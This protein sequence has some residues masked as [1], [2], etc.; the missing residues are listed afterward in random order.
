MLILLILLT[1]IVIGFRTIYVQK[2]VASVASVELS[3]F[4]HYKVEIDRLEIDWFDHITVYGI[5]VYDYQNT[6]MIYLGEVQIDY[7]I[8]TF[9]KSFAYRIQEATLKDGEVHLINYKNTDIININEFI[10]GLSKV[11]GPSTDTVNATKPFTIQDVKLINMRFAFDDFDNEHISGFDHNHFSF[12]SIYG[13]T[14]DL[15]V[16]A[17]TLRI[18]IKDLTTI[19]GGTHMRVHKLSGVYTLCGHY[20]EL[21]NMYAR[22]GNSFLQN[23]I[24]FSYSTIT[25]LADF[26]TKT[27]IKSTLDS[28]FIDL[29]DISHFASAL[30]P[31]PYKIALSGNVSGT[32]NKFSISKLNLYT[33]KSFLRGS[34]HM[35]GLPDFKKTYIDANFKDVNINQAE[36]A[37]FFNSDIG[38]TLKIVNYFKGSIKFNGFPENFVANAALNTAIGFV[39]TDMAFHL[40][41]NI[42]DDSYYSGKLITKNLNIG[43][44]IKSDQLGI[45]NMDGSVE[46]VGFDINK[47][48]MKMVASIHSIEYNKYNYKNIHTDAI[49]QK[50]L[51]N[52][53]LD[54]L[55]SN[56]VMQIDGMLDYRQKEK[57]LQVTVA[58][59][60]AKLNNLNLHILNNDLLVKTNL[61]IDF[62]GTEIDDAYGNGYLTNTYLLYN[63]NKEIFI[64]TLH[65]V[66]EIH[67]DTS[68]TLEINS[69]VVSASINGNFKPTIIVQDFAKFVQE[70][71]AVLQMTAWM[72]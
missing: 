27:Y 53:H 25:D 62:K 11:L 50:A 68:R 51:F 45:I 41:E 65:L 47:L 18:A 39:K 38:S 19:E 43:K 54:I 13:V 8:F 1:I 17:D 16:F 71:L 12:D 52:G 24:R 46:G 59:E 69:N 15:Y 44:L 28:S 26:N 31:Y 22:I 49:L 61:T 48:K 56:L 9:E 35:D 23:Y 57:I 37:P 20:M 6:R 10:D 34:L 70:V 63:G 4:L 2:K 29:R 14:E 7:K 67:N 3:D 21:E 32:V 36:L 40:K 64:D 42:I 5:S 60:K 66:S 72:L 30:K 58:C 33:G 55:D